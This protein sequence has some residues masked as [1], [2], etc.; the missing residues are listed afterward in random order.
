[1]GGVELDKARNFIALLASSL[2]HCLTHKGRAVMDGFPPGMDEK[3]TA[4]LCG[5]AARLQG[6]L[7][8]GSQFQPHH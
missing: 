6:F 2:T 4:H 3:E 7:P 1:M 5:L 8:V